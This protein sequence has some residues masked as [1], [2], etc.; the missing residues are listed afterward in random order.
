MEVFEYISGILTWLCSVTR[1]AM[2]AQPLQTTHR[3][4][5]QQEYAQKSQA[6]IM[7]NLIVKGKT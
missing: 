1:E 2:S 5:G 7:D 4:V 6:S 3:P